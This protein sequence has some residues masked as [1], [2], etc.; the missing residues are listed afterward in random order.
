MWKDKRSV[1]RPSPPV[2]LYTHVSGVPICDKVDQ[3]AWRT[4]QRNGED[5]MTRR[6][7]PRQRALRVI[8][9]RILLWAYVKRSADSNSRTTPKKP[10]YLSKY[11]DVTVWTTEESWVDPH[12]GKES[13]LFC[14]TSRPTLRLTQSLLQW[15][16][17]ALSRR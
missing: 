16:L 5:K 6:G 11:S 10:G 4:Q 7:E 14:K 3:R 13:F 15:L 2:T 8:G 12:Q 9:L 17:E 1:T